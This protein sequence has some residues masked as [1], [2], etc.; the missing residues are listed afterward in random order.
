MTRRPPL[1]LLLLA[2]VALSLVLPA[3]A[4]LGWRRW[5]AR[6]AT[7]VAERDLQQVAQQISSLVD[8]YLDQHRQAVASFALLVRPGD[9]R[10]PLRLLHSRY[11]GFLTMIIVDRQGQRV[12]ATRGAALVA[13]G[14]VSDVADREYFSEPMRT[15]SMYL[16]GAFQ[17]RGLGRD[18][19]VALS[20]ALLDDRG[21]RSGVV[22]GSLDLTRFGFSEDAFPW[23]DS[24]N[25]IITDHRGLVVYGGRYAQQLPLTPLPPG[26][27]A[28]DDQLSTLSV[29]PSS[30]WRVLATQPRSVVL[31]DV[32]RFS[33]SLGMA[34]AAALMLGLALAWFVSRQILRPMDQV[35]RSIAGYSAGSA[36]PTIEP[37]ALVPAEISLLAR[38]FHG[39]A[40]RVNGQLAGFIPICMSCKRIRDATGKWEAVEVY[41][42]RHS[43]AEFTHSYCPPCAHAVMAS[44]DVS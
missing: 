24:L 29:A 32:S 15:G 22:E 2:L 43:D 27:G 18:P 42:R 1:R 12:V 11:P 5:F 14:E 20:A 9:Y 21:N 25:V 35:V 36:P 31:R 41:V 3:G 38:S 28:G 8:R 33:R 4:V 26:A 44:A 39:M 40:R 30:R 34:I 37:S 16:S 17:G 13:P 6:E 7:Q 19:I 10:E 23:L